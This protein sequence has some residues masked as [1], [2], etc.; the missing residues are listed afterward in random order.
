M[1]TICKNRLLICLVTKIQ[2]DRSFLRNSVYQTQHAQGH[3]G[4][5]LI[6]GKYTRNHYVLLN[7]AYSA[8]SVYSNYFVLYISDDFMVVYY[9]QA[10]KIDKLELAWVLS[11]NHNPDLSDVEALEK[12]LTDNGIY[13]D[14]ITV[15]QDKCKQII[16]N[17]IFCTKITKKQTHKQTNRQT[18]K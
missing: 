5:L 4:K 17:W 9:C 16:A 18:T 13:L 10:N 6:N 11:R 14:M 7:T 15:R 1:H 12:I 3:E 8:T 2:V